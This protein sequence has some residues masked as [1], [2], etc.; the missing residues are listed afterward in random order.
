MKKLGTL[1]GCQF[2]R[3]TSFLRQTNDSIPETVW[4]I[5]DGLDEVAAMEEGDP[6]HNVLKK[7]SACGRPPF[8]ISC[9][10]AEWRGVTA[11]FDIADDYGDAPL[12]LHLEPFSDEEAINMGTI[13][14]TSHL[15]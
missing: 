4:L 9:R 13:R 15:F 6:L 7:L 10:A 5:I 12:E 2:I 14:Y 3:A 11:R 8:I 1:D